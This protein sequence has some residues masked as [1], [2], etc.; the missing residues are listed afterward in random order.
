VKKQRFFD[1][2]DCFSNNGLADLCQR[3]QEGGVKGIAVCD[4]DNRDIQRHHIIGKILQ[5]YAD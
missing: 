5:L 4:L 2:F 3:L 1:Y